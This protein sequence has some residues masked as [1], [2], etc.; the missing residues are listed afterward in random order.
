MISYNNINIGLAINK[1]HQTGGLELHLAK[2]Y[3]QICSKLTCYKVEP[4]LTFVSILRRKEALLN[5]RCQND[6]GKTHGGFKRS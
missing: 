1:L 3:R 2:N 5:D 4:Y 6:G